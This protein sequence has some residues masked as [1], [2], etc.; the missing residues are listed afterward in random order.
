MLMILGSFCRSLMVEGFDRGDVRSGFW[1]SIDVNDFMVVLLIAGGGR[2]RWRSLSFAES[3][4]CL[5][6]LQ[7]R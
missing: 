1:L 5:I 2:I 4:C 6:G 3:W 7:V